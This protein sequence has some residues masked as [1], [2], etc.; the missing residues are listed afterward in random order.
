MKHT[1]TIFLI[2]LSFYVT[3][4][5]S[6]STPIENN[7]N[8]SIKETSTIVYHI[9]NTREIIKK[10]LDDASNQE[11]NSNIYGFVVL[12]TFYE[13]RDYQAAWTKTKNIDDALSS[14]KDLYNDGLDPE[15]YHYTLLKEMA[16]KF[17]KSTII[18]SVEF[19]KFDVYMSDAIITAAAHLISGKVHPE[20]LKR[21]WEVKTES[22][23]KVFPNPGEEL[24]IA[25]DSEKISEI[26]NSLKPKHYMY[27]GLKKALAEY[28]GYL[29]NGNWDSIA[30]GATIKLGDKSERVLNVRARLLASNEM[31]EYVPVNDSIYDSIL[32]ANM[33]VF[34]KKYGI[35]VD[36]NVGKQTLYELN[37][38]LTYRIEQIK[39][40]MERGRWVLYQIEKKFI[41]VNIAGFE[42]YFVEDGKEVLTS[43][44]IVGKSHTMSPI[45][46]D[47]MQ[48]VVINPT[49]TV[50]RSLYPGYI[51][52]LQN[53]PGYFAQKDMEIITTS[54]QNVPIAGK[55]WSGY[56][57]HN[58]PYMIRQKAGPN[59]SLGLIKCMFPN[60]HSVYIHDTPARSL[61]SKDKRAFSHGCIRTQEIHEVALKLLEPNNDGWTAEKIN[62]II[63]TR[64]TTTISLKEKVPVL[65]LYW[66]AGIGFNQNFY[67]K[68]DVYHRDQV[69]IDAL[70]AKIK[71]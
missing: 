20:S 2:I 11:L 32:K 25:L 38:P 15:D 33:E 46:K 29:E 52:K 34:Q 6:N 37:I 39:A 36:G 13:N 30:E 41:A 16:D 64:K 4:C 67:F 71:Y 49:W 35:E 45:F 53:N 61:F 60:K 68:P 21:Q 26:L 55:D 65:I 24:K 12:K 27:S 43:R 40:N 31:Q 50:P 54:G 14:I 23:E 17:T 1:I 69:L 59:N 47:T 48:Y 22:L 3:S 62:Q 28:R 8:E 63:E 5:E 10:I 70:N 51:K 19:A 66:T 9:G 56:T 18:D 42:L 57:V 44:V 58:F 7:N